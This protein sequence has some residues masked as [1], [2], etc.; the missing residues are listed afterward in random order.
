M[1]NTWR[2]G[3]A[4]NV[5]WLT[6]ASLAAKPFWLAFV[7]VLCW[8]YLGT[9][10]FG[11]FSTALW[12]AFI[13]AALTDLGLTQLTIRDI[14]RSQE[15][16]SVYFSNIFGFR[17]LISPIAWAIAMIAGLLIGYSAH[18]LWAV[19]WAGCPM[20]SG[21]RAVTYLRG[22]FR[23]FEN[24]KLEGISTIVEKVLVVAAGCVGPVRR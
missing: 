7:V 24:L 2:I 4:R 3:I 19:A 21:F 20:E 9:Q 15:D 10:E 23:A 8:R 11:V 1:S 5:T 13:P 22:Y 6:V 14:A 12:L 18:M 16:S 17:L